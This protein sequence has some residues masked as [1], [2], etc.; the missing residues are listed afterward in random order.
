MSWPN[1]IV[2]DPNAMERD[3]SA[4]YGSGSSG[5]VAG[6]RSVMNSRSS[7]GVCT[8]AGALVKSGF[9]CAPMYNTGVG[10]SGC[11]VAH[12]ARPSGTAIAIATKQADFTHCATP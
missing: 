1:R 6:A 11:V 12:P 9:A 10:I 2:V 7:G 8:S 4:V 5:F 3:L